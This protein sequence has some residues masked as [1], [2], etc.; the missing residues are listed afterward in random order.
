MK[1]KKDIYAYSFCMVLALIIIGMS[2]NMEQF[3]SK[4]FPMIISFAIL[5][6]SAIGLANRFRISKKEIRAEKAFDSVEVSKSMWHSRYAACYSLFCCYF[7][8]I[9]GLGFM[10]ATPLFVLAYA[11]LR[12][13]KWGL[14]IGFGA[15]VTVFQYVVF[16]L[17]MKINLYPGLLF[18]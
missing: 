1:I 10:I 5:V 15:A 3:D 11:K 6:L 2:L 8:V 12:G 14:S 4:I 9:Y 18:K 16:D 7:I 13:M 17:A